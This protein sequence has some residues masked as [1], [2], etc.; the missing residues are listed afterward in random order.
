MRRERLTLRATDAAVVS[1]FV[2]DVSTDFPLTADNMGV[3]AQ[4]RTT[5]R[6]AMGTTSGVFTNVGPTASGTASA[7]VIT[8][9]S[10]SRS[11]GFRAAM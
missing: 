9:A 6:I 7:A 2:P 11:F 10:R 1:L 5:W 3:D 8:G 4:G